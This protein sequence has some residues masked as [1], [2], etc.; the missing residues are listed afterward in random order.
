M[1][2]IV[3][4]RVVAKLVI[5]FIALFGFYV[6]LHGEI[7]PGGGFQ[8]GVVIAASIILYGLI[9]GLNA[10]QKVYPRGFAI[11]L[12]ALG[13]LTYTGVAAYTIVAGGELLNYSNLFINEIHGQ[14]R[15]IFLVEMGVCITVTNVM[16][17]IYYLF[18]SHQF[19]LA[20]K[21][22]E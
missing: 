19:T 20:S 5:P 10:V 14:H 12:S 18:A 1:K 21:G 16:V 2:D 9:F 3:V 22:D 8:S 7:S 6:Q 13:L 15:G 4:L 11:R 17:L